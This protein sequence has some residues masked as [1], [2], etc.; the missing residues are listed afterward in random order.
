MEN[1]TVH[2]CKGTPGPACRAKMTPFHLHSVRPALCPPGE[3]SEGHG[4][5]QGREGGSV[6][7]RRKQ[8]KLVKTD[9]ELVFATRAASEEPSPGTGGFCKFCEP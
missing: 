4:M 2:P 1:N 9:L 3:Q 8:G 7:G 5:A 6:M